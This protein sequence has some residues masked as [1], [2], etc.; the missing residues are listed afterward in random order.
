VCRALCPFSWVFQDTLSLLLGFLNYLEDIKWYCKGTMVKNDIPIA[1]LHNFYLTNLLEDGVQPHVY[2]DLVWLIENTGWAL[3]QSI[4][5]D[6]RVICFKLSEWRV[7]SIE[8]VGQ[9]PVMREMGEMKWKLWDQWSFSISRSRCPNTSTWGNECLELTH[10]SLMW[11]V[12]DDIQASVILRRSQ[13][14]LTYLEN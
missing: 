1:V 6:K 7:K 13:V 2:H 11:I 3:H 14:I 5:T 4:S 12:W 10:E 9:E 8:P